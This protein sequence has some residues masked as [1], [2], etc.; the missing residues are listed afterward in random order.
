[1]GGGD[2]ASALL[3]LANREVQ[4]ADHLLSVTYPMAKEPK[5]LLSVADHGARAIEAAAHAAMDI[6]V[7][8]AEGLPRG[9]PSGFPDLADPS[10]G[11][12]IEAS[13]TY[14]RLR[15]MVELFQ[16]A[17]TAF[18]RGDRFVIAYD[19]FASL[20]EVTPEELSEALITVKRFVHDTGRHMIIGGA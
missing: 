8:D 17:P 18:P 13:E 9:L 3:L 19:G 1:M 10:I 7:V 15:G 6:A 16:D 20:R 11:S 4:V 2:S 14:R 5:L 12:A